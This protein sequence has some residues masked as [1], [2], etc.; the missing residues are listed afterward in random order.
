MLSQPLQIWTVGHSNQ[1]AADFARLLLAHRVEALADVR[2]HPGSRRLPHFNEDALR[3]ALA[4]VQATLAGRSDGEAP[5]RARSERGATV[6]AQAAPPPVGTSAAIEYHSFRDLGGMRQ[7]RPDSRNIAWRHDSFRGYADYIETPEFAAAAARL[8]ELA[9]R[10][11]TAVMCAE[12][13]WRQC[14]RSLLSDWLK[15][16]G[17]AVIH[18]LSPARSEP[19]PWTRPARIVDG[20][21]SYE[22]APEPTLFD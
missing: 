3:A 20:R 17:V 4:D 14:H 16:R 11:R 22:A 7:P 1:S 18:I 10:R 15:W 21:L 9:A 8:L 19:H 6:D 5:Q 13:N 2:R 12:A